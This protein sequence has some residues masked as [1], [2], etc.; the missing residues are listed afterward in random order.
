LV[1]VNKN[2]IE[3]II[4]APA[5]APAAGGKAPPKG[6]AAA[7]THD[8]T[9][10]EK[11]DL[12]LDETAANNF[13]L[14]DALEQIIKLNYEARAKLKHPQTPNWL[15]LKLCLVGYP[16]AGKK[17]SANY[18]KEKYGLD[19]F[20]MESLIDEAREAANAPP[21]TKEAEEAKDGDA[22]LDNS[23]KHES[24]DD[25]ISED[26]EEKSEA[27]AD[28]CA[29]GRE[30]E[31]LLFSGEEI[32]DEIYVRL[33]V[34]KLRITYEY[35][36]PRQKLREMKNE[37]RRTVEIKDRLMDIETTLV[38]E[39]ETLSKKATKNM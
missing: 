38:Q 5:E 28:F 30:I 36:S 13:L 9:T 24:E 31:D 2:L 15:A 12:E 1:S 11:D 19:I 7:A 14:G 16:F 23:S 8:A 4:N 35:K 39:A 17:V 21:K 10:L 6:K 33:F 34:A 32:S 22:V 3:Q 18:I 26:E 37:A 25:S 27:L 20:Q 29:I